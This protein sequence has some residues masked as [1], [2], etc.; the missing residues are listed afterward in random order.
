MSKESM[1]QFLDM[2]AKNP[3]VAEKV[4]EVAQKGPQAFLDYAAERGCEI[5]EKDLKE[6]GE[7][8]VEAL[9][10]QVKE[11]TEKLLSFLEKDPSPQNEGMKNLIRLM[12]DSEED[13]VVTHKLNE[14]VM[15]DPSA[16][17]DYGKERGYDFTEKDL[18]QFGKALLEQENELN[19]EELDQVAGGMDIVLGLALESPPEPYKVYR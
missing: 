11:Q 1:Q 5:E 19:D 13:E 15:R 12:K 17:V 16:I 9:N 3:E 4:K 6:L 2:M 10:K 7:K 14:L 8:A 18:L